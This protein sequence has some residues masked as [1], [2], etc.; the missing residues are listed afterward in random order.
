LQRTLPDL[1]VKGRLMLIDP[2]FFDL[3]LAVAYIDK[4]TVPYHPDAFDERSTGVILEKTRRA[5]AVSARDAKEF[6]V[7]RPWRTLA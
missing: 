6:Y 2:A 5:L 7:W 4:D 1:N 3:A